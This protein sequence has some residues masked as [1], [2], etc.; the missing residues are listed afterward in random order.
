MQTRVSYQFEML[1]K[2]TLPYITRINLCSS[3]LSLYSFSVIK[4]NVSLAI[5]NACFA[6]VFISSLLIFLSNFFPCANAVL[7]LFLTYV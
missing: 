2:P 5:I 7:L 3:I 1:A 4:L 6:S